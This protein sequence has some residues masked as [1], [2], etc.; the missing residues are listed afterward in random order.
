MIQNKKSFELENPVVLG[1]QSYKKVHITPID[2]AHLFKDVGLDGVL[3]GTG[4]GITELV[5][6]CGEFED[7]NPLPK[8]IALG[9]WDLL[10]ATN[11]VNKC[12]KQAG[13][14]DEDSDK[15]DDGIKLKH[16][17]TFEDKQQTHVKFK[18][19]TIND[20]LNFPMATLV[21]KYGWAM[22]ALIREHA[23]FGDGS[24]IPKG[25]ESQMSA[26]DYMRC[27]GQISFFLMDLAKK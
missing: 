17:L 18:P 11:A 26:V 9:Y 13:F 3:R 4:T 2:K 5:Q 14:F 20:A 25:F 8:D 19:F 6:V 15:S 22:F 21:N 12:L 1:K 10:A 27:V 16:P 23:T 24:K 7:G